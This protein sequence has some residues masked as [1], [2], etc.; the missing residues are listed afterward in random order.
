MNEKFEDISPE[1]K[2]MLQSLADQIVNL[3]TATFRELERWG[4]LGTSD[5]YYAASQ[6]LS[7]EE[8]MSSIRRLRK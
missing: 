3:K 2:K 1:D 4:G 8:L 5:A 6:E 7:D